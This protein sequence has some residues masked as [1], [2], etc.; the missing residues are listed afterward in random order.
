VCSRGPTWYDA[1]AKPG[2]VAPGHRL[3]G[4]ASTGRYLYQTYP[5]LRG[6]VYGTS[7]DYVYL[8]NST[9]LVSSPVQ[10]TTIDG[11]NIVWAVARAGRCTGRV[12]RVRPAERRSSEH[13]L[14]LLQVVLHIDQQAGELHVV[15][16]EHDDGGRIEE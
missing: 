2:L 1:C 15:E 6:P 16:S 3:L 5:T 12:R 10:N 7:R 8:S 11:Q 4:F 13:I 14:H 9:W